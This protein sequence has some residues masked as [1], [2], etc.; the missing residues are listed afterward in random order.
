VCKTSISEISNDT[1]LAVP[2]KIGPILNPVVHSILNDWLRNDSNKTPIL[3]SLMNIDKPIADEFKAIFGGQGFTY[4]RENFGYI[5]QYFTEIFPRTRNKKQ[6]KWI[7]IFL[8]QYADR[9][10]CTKLPIL[11]KGLQTITS[12][13]SGKLVDKSVDKLLSS[14]LNLS[15]SLL[16][17]NMLSLKS[18]FV[19]KRFYSVYDTYCEYHFKEIVKGKLNPKRGHLR[20]H[21]YGSRFNLSF[22]GVITP[23]CEY[24]YGDEVHIP[25]KIGL[26]VFQYHIL[27][28][29]TNRYKYTQSEG[30][31]LIQNSYKKYNFL[32]DKIMQEIVSEC[33]YKGF[34]ILLNRNPSLVLESIQL[35]YITKVKPALKEDP[36]KELKSSTII[37]DDGSEK[38]DW[39][40]TFVNEQGERFDVSFTDDEGKK[41]TTVAKIKSIDSDVNERLNFLIE[42]QTIGIS[43]L[44][45]TGPNA[46]FDGDEENGIILPEMDEVPKFFNLHPIEQVLSTDD[47]AMGHTLKLTDQLCLMLTEWINQ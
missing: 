25:W 37:V 30:Y 23:I 32:I 26:S 22:R 11:A 6:T 19:E 46:D 3:E 17:E 43:P 45:I 33:P 2:E 7:P 13:D 5:I 9:I 24:H 41:A 44:C 28:I 15:D 10:W 18:K 35:F 36:Y 4:F 42:D 16:M 1:W 40:D 8:D 39:T 34:P 20:R 21:L 14:I 38:T 12:T 29:L 31:N 27:A 47:I